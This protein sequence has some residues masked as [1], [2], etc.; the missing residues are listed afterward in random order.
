MRVLVPAERGSCSG[1]ARVPR[2]GSAAGCEARLCL[3]G[4]T[5][6][7]ESGCAPG[8]GL[9][10][11]AIGHTRGVALLFLLGPPARRS[12]ASHPAAEPCREVVLLVCAAEPCREVVQLVCAAELC[13]E[14]V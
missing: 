12:L 9:P 4:R 7:E 10:F 14:V 5:T 1:Y 6:K 3:A 13:R 11:W 2:Y 8:S